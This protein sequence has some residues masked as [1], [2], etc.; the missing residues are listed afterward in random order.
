LFVKGTHGPE[1]VTDVRVGILA[2]NQLIS[3]ACNSSILLTLKTL[4]VTVL[5]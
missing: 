1:A 4:S 3:F 5:V 2:L